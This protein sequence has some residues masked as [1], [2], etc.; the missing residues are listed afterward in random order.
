MPRMRSQPE[1][2][3]VW[4]RGKP[5]F[6]PLD[7]P[8]VL[9]EFF[10]GMEQA[11]LGLVAQHAQW[12]RS[13]GLSEMSNVARWH[14]TLG[15]ILRH[16]AFVDQLD[17]PQ[18]VGAEYICRELVKVELAVERNPRAPDWDG[19]QLITGSRLTDTG[20]IN[21]REFNSWL[22]SAQKDAA[23]VLKQQRL[24]REEAASSSKNNEKGKKE[25]KTGE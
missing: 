23:I 19:L 3:Q 15:E 10:E 2:L 11:G 6:F 24:L 9:P 21:L 1:L 13:A 4:S 25:E 7:G 5:P 8:P 16:L 22:S 18:V 14:K 12:V 17:L 20:G